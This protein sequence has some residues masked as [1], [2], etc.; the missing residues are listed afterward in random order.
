MTFPGNKDNEL[1]VIQTS[2][3]SSIFITKDLFPYDDPG[4]EQLC[5][6]IS[7]GYKPLYWLNN[8]HTD[9]QKVINLM[10]FPKRNIS[11]KR[12]Y[13]SWWLNCRCV[14]INDSLKSILKKRLEAYH[15]TGEILNTFRNAKYG[16]EF[17]VDCLLD[18][19][20][21]LNVEYDSQLLELIPKESNYWDNEMNTV[22]IY[23]EGFISLPYSR[24]SLKTDTFPT[25]QNF[26]DYLFYLIK[27]EVNQF[28]YGEE[29]LLFNTISGLILQKDYINALRSLNE[30]KIYHDNKIICYKLFPI[31]R[32]RSNQSDG[33]I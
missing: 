30:N 22:T 1:L 25:F 33:V 26:L 19:H 5:Y 3:S 4:I 13:I 18:W 11:C 17:N 23:F 14:F 32:T 16:L 15:L 21:I 12:D 6:S 9:L 31:L 20:T 29:W 24:I 7:E 8:W 10:E 28:S 27:N 2:D